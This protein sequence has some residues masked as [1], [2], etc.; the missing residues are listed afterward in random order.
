M[1]QGRVACGM[2]SVAIICGKREWWAPEVL[3]AT[4]GHGARGG[5]GDHMPALLVYLVIRV[6]AHTADKVRQG[7]CEKRRHLAAKVSG[8]ILP[9]GSHSLQAH[10]RGG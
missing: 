6:R 5:A 1:T 8:A 9:A 2:W 7:L 4:G 10:P 3:V